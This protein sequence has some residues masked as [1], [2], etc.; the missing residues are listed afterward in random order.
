MSYR[1]LSLILGLIGTLSVS[2]QQSV[3]EN[4]AALTDEQKYAQAQQH[5]ENLLRSNKSAENYAGLAES[6][7]LQNK[8]HQALV[9]LRE[10]SKNNFGKDANVAAVGGHVSYL[11]ANS[12]T[13]SYVRYKLFMEA[14]VVLCKRSLA[15]DP[16]NQIALDTL[17]MVTSK[18]FEKAREFERSGDL[19]LAQD[20]YE[21][22]LKENKDDSKAKYGLAKVVG[23]RLE[24]GANVPDFDRIS[25]ILNFSDL[26]SGKTSSLFAGAL[27]EIPA[28]TK[29]RIVFETPLNSETSK[30][31]DKFSVRTLE[32]MTEINGYVV[33]PEGSVIKGTVVQA[34]GWASGQ[35]ISQK[36]IL[37][38]RFDSIEATGIAAMP[39]VAKLASHGGVIHYIRNGDNLSYDTATESPHMPTLL[40]SAF[41]AKKGKVIDVKV[42]DQFK[43]EFL[44]GLKV[45]RSR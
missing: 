29:V 17:K 14:A 22:L 2:V 25:K 31:E 8:I 20:E 44:E 43:L 42:G 26:K 5:Y 11:T 9:V 15:I 3:A 34:N 30:P 28:Q 12:V 32:P 40:T 4:R 45:K 1:L 39:V 24:N 18:R 6:L 37:Q 38:L 7:A 16:H 10:A 23:L 27:D 19:L 21:D 41:I 36:G 13:V 35:S 33:F